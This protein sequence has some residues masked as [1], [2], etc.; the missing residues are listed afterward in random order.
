MAGRELLKLLVQPCRALTSGC[1]NAHTRN[2][3]RLA[4]ADCGKQQLAETWRVQV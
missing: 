2:D 3:N 1:S 4:N